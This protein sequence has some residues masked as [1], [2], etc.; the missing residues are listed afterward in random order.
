MRPLMLPAARQAFS[1][2][3]DVARLCAD[4]GDEDARQRLIRWLARTGQLSELHERAKTGDD[5]A[6]YCGR[7]CTRMS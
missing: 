5:Y 1:P 3:M 7:F 4:L 2:G 6:R